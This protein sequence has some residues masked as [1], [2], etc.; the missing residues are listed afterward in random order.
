MSAAH[1]TVKTIRLL[2]KI[3]L[4]TIGLYAWI[5]EAIPRQQLPPETLKLLRLLLFAA[6]A[7]NV[8]LAMIF[9]R[10]K[11][12]GA[13][14]NLAR[15][16]EDEDALLQWRSGSFLTYV[17]CETVALF[18]LV[19]RFLGGT[20]PEAG[21]LYVVAAALLIVWAPRGDFVRET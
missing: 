13:E 8:V 5:G 21:T 11:V 4:V 18:G 20:L 9:G 15:S 16:A 6:A 14:E 7:S 3:F 19:L 17:F 10:R 2:H 12:E 1:E